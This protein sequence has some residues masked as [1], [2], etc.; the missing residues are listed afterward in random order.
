MSFV[1]VNSSLRLINHGAY[2]FSLIT[3]ES[4][5]LSCF[6]RRKETDR[7]IRN[8][9][10]ELFDAPTSNIRN[11]VVLEQMGCS[12]NQKEHVNKIRDYVSYTVLQCSATLCDTIRDSVV[13]AKHC[14]VPFQSECRCV[15][16]LIGAIRPRLFYE[17]QGC[18]DLHNIAMT[19]KKAYLGFSSPSALSWRNRQE[20]GK[21]FGGIW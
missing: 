14:Y 5:N 19:S 1:L 7:R 3:H 21:E 17:N 6:Q 8:P 11:V 20:K 15:I 10:V 13:Q 2:R 9:R 16:E 18:C 12:A 4:A